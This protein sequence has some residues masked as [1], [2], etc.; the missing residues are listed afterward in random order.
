MSGTYLDSDTIALCHA[1]MRD[2]QS[3]DDL[4]GKLHFSPVTLAR[5]L[6]LPTVKPVTADEVDLWRVSEL[7]SQL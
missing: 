7:E 2:G 3:L 1:A 6:G 4:A 5:L